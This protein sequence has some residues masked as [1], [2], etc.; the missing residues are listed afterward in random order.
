MDDEQR[1]ENTFKDLERIGNYEHPL[2]VNLKFGG[3]KGKGDINK[4]QEKYFR[5]NASDEEKFAHILEAVFYNWNDTL[6]FDQT[7]LIE[8]L[9]A[10]YGIR[11]INSKNPTCYLF[12]YYIVDKGK[13]QPKI[14]KTKLQEI[15]DIIKH[16]TDVTDVDVIRYCRL[17]LNYYTDE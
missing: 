5:I 8:M 11:H 10:V 15:K 13:S 3:G 9:D 14:N 16:Q 4:V 1:F 17:W 6:H 7:N 12:G 2:L